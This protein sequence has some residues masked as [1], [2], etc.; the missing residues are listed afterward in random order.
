MESKGLLADSQAGFR[1]NRCTTVQ[2]LKM[3]QLA[4][5][6][7]QTRRAESATAIAFFDY[8]KAYNKVWRNGLLFKM[9][10]LN[11]PQ[12]IIRYTRSNRKTYVEVNGAR[13]KSFILKEVLQ[14]GSA[15]LLFLI[16]INDIDVDLHDETIASLFAD[17][18]SI[19]RHGGQEDKLKNL[20]QSEVNKILEWAKRWK[21]KINADKMK[22][23]VISSKN[24]D[25][26]WNIGLTKDGKEL[27]TTDEFK[28]LGVTINNGLNLQDTSTG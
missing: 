23:M 21:M 22:A 2:I 7:I 18:T 11:I 25:Q 24:A 19:G 1:Q 27:E 17:D 6:N 26:K 9:Q 12:K 3:T 5:D 14:Q 15:P 20:M 8:A 16:F 13:S 4:T 10:E 28:F